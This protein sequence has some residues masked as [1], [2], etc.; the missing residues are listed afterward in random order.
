VH[1]DTPRSLEDW[2]HLLSISHQFGIEKIRNRA[3]TALEGMGLG[4]VERIV[5]AVNHDISAWLKPAYVDL[6]ERKE[7]LREDEAR[8]LGLS[9]TVKLACARERLREAQKPQR[10]ARPE[11][12]LQDSY[13]YHHQYAIAQPDSPRP[14]SSML[15]PDSDHRYDIVRA[16]SPKAACGTTLASVPLAESIIKEIF[17]PATTTPSLD[18]EF[19]A[20]VAAP[21]GGKKKK[22]GRRK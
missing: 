13:D 15:L 8:E 18:P 11:F 22:K 16:A 21:K 7:A 1:E 17:D 2:T 3:I 12:E 10:G 4:P 19:E 5:L 6:C 14:P 9:T 20:V